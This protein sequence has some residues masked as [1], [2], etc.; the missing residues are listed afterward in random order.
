MRRFLAIVRATALEIASEPLALLLTLSALAMAVLTPALHY[1][2]FGE[3]SRMARDAGLS[4]ILVGGLLFSLF[5]TVRAFRQEIESGTLQMALAHSVS[6]A[7]FFLAKLTG[8]LAAVCLFALTLA[9]TTLTVVNGAEIG[10]RVAAVSGEVSPIWGRSFAC[11]VSA[12]V[13][14]PVLAA[15]LNRFARFRFTLTAT[16]LTAVCAVLGAAYRFDLPLAVR[17][18]PVAL[19]VVLPLVVMTSASA[20]FAVR[21]REQAALSATGLLLAVSLPFMGNYY[22]SDVLYKGGALPVSYLMTA[23][24]VTL[25]LVAAFAM[26]G[27]MLLERRDVGGGV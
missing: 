26:T 5:C 6:R 8:I 20:V 9:A 1:H 21:W 16:V 23:L 22:L 10:A 14:P 15:V 27:I 25:P 24:A 17:F 7:T 18:L 3:P 13:V 2:Q 11:A 12:L 19:L 4:A